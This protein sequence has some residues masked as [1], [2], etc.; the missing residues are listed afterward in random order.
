MSDIRSLEDMFESVRERPGMWIPDKS[1]A[2][3]ETMVHGYT[4]ALRAHE[5]VEFGVEFN[6]RFSAFVSDRLGWTTSC[7]WADA[8]TTNCIS[9]DA[10]FE[11]F[12][13]LLDEFRRAS[14]R[15]PGL[16]AG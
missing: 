9:A 11:R 2:R 10:A 7:G 13:S 4:V 5:V 15:D 3:L 6:R 1:L 8:I 12:F 16:D 14:P